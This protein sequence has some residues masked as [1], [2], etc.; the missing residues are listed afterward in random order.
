MG[1]PF[2][3]SYFLLQMLLYLF[4]LEREGKAYFGKDVVP[5]GVLYFPARD[6]LVG[7]G[8]EASAE[9]IRTALDKELRRT[10]LVLSQPEV[11]HAMEHS[12]L[13]ET[14]FLPVKVGRGGVV[15][16]LASAEELGK[17]SRFV[18][19]LLDDI[20]GELSGGNIDADPC[21]SSENDSACTYCEF[22]SACHFTDGEGGDH[23]ELIRPVTPEE[24]WAQ[25]DEAIRKEAVQW[26]YN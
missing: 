17:L 23:M 19:K 24:F 5:A 18:D 11:L 3:L 26:P 6:V 4:A 16:G 21:G 22:A 9:D 12:S 10:G 7:K 8:R 2:A 20:A 1:S 25:V 14:R 15:S 13:E